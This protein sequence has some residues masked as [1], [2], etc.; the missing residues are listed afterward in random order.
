MVSPHGSCAQVSPR[1]V[2]FLSVPEVTSVPCKPEALN[3]NRAGTFYLNRGPS[4]PTIGRGTGRY[5]VHSHGK[6]K[7]TRWNWT[8]ARRRCCSGF[9][10]TVF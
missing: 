6:G 4:R 2:R 10:R 5:R 3:P 9:R 7:A 1:I 8:D